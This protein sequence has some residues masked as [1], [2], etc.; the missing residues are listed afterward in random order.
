MRKQNKLAVISSII[1]LSAVVPVL[2]VTCYQK[3]APFSV[4]DSTSIKECAPVYDEY[5]DP[6][7][8]PC[9][10]DG[11]SE[12]TWNTPNCMQDEA[13]LSCSFCDVVTET[14]T[15]TLKIGSCSDWLAREQDP[16][17]LCPLSPNGVPVQIDGSALNVG[18]DCET[19]PERTGGS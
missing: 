7:E 6:L 13:I 10:G 11:C 5:G 17:C 18:T 1:A 3:A 9:T 14:I 4:V 16:E 15:A 19:C 2:A 12:L 8:V